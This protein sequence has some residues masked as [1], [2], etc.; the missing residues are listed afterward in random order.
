MPRYRRGKSSS[1]PHYDVAPISF[2][3]NY[4][5]MLRLPAEWLA[6]SEAILRTMYWSEAIAVSEFTGIR[7]EWSVEP[8][9]VHDPARPGNFKL[10]CTAGNM[11][12]PPY[13]VAVDGDYEAIS[14]Q[15]R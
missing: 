11:E 7:Y 12:E 14:N 8:G 10:R 15:M 1:V 6:E 2:A 3:A 4:K 13:D 5:E 9:T